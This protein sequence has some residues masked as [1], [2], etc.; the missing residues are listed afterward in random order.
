M[1]VMSIKKKKDNLKVLEKRLKALSK[2][3]AHVGL[4]PEQG[5][6]KPSGMLYTELMWLHDSGSPSLRIP[7][8]PVA[9]LAMLSFDGKEELRRDI[10]K[11]LSG[12][13]KP[14]QITTQTLAEN[15]AKSMWRTSYDIFGD[16]SKLVPNSAYTVDLKGH[17][18]PLIETGEL[19]DNWSAWVNGKKIK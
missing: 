16:L 15:W 17:N 8:R 5:I 14:L 9:E 2:V 3:K 11:Y 10:K 7:A 12:L 13:D 6:H 4:K 18:T 19:Q 1:V